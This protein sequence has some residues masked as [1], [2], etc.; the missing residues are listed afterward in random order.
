MQIRV[1]CHDSPP[2]LIQTMTLNR[3][4][5]D[6]YWPGILDFWRL[7]LHWI[8]FRPFPPRL[9][10]IPNYSN[11]DKL[12]KNAWHLFLWN[13]VNLMPGN[14]LGWKGYLCKKKKKESEEKWA[15]HSYIYR[16]SPGGAGRGWGRS[17]FLGIAFFHGCSKDVIAAVLLSHFRCLRPLSALSRYCLTF[18][19]HQT[20]EIGGSCSPVPFHLDVPKS[21]KLYLYIYFSIGWRMPGLFNMIF[22]GFQFFEWYCD[23]V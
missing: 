11:Q 20:T 12:V 8:L 9:W 16:Q 1:D 5:W 15:P 19:G 3:S 17:C 23:V 18:H 13:P 7:T 22:N 6:L 10:W 2:C 21:F 14:N 4:D